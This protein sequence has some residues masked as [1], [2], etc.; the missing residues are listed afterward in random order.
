MARRAKQKILVAVPAKF[1]PDFIEK[2]S[3]RFTLTRVVRERRDA[4]EQH[5]G[6]DLTCIQHSLIKR[7]VWLELI[8]ET[9]EQKF[10]NGEDVDVGA[11]TQL[12]N[13]LKGLYKDLG[14][15]ASP[16]PVKPL[17]AFM[18]RSEKVPAAAA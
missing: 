10:V 15:K 6:G 2:L 16:K 3:K 11:I 17:S 5:V 4:L 13:S 1:D 14:I 18:A 9:Y 12:T 7:T 8:T